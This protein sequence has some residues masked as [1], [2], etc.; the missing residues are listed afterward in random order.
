MRTR[1]TYLLLQGFHA[2]IAAIRLPVTPNQKNSSFDEKKKFN[3][4]YTRLPDEKEMSCNLYF[5]FLFFYFDICLSRVFYEIIWNFKFHT[6]RIT[7]N[8]NQIYKYLLK[9]SRSNI[10]LLLFIIF[11]LKVIFL[12]IYILYIYFIYRGISVYLYRLRK[13]CLQIPPPYYTK[14]FVPNFLFGS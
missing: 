4:Y 8:V 12:E 10:L 13:K 14:L 1:K 3:T 5:I 7:H 2:W 9:H 6:K 11:F